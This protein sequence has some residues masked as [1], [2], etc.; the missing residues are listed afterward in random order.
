M[1]N[2]FGGIIKSQ[3]VADKVESAFRF[4]V[5]ASDRLPIARKFVQTLLLKSSGSSKLD[6]PSELL[7][8]D[9]DAVMSVLCRFS[10]YTDQR[11]RLNAIRSMGKLGQQTTLDSNETQ[12][13]EKLTHHDS[14]VRRRASI[15]LGFRDGLAPETHSSLAHLSADVR[16]WVRQAVKHVELFSQMKQERDTAR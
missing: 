11:I 6:V 10:I 16:P 14:S 15:V 2:P 5:I 3:V 12:L 4:E 9:I 8:S 1:G 7:M 13:V